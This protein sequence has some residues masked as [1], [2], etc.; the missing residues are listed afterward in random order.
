MFWTRVANMN[1]IKY[2]RSR[3]EYPVETGP[4]KLVG[5]RLQYRWL[6]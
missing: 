6:V 2:R 3:S 4:W 5:G 1:M